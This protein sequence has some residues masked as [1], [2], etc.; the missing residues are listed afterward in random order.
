M[1][2]KSQKGRHPEVSGIQT[3]WEFHE[4]VAFERAKLVSEA[5]E[6]RFGELEKAMHTILAKQDSEGALALITRGALALGSSDIHYDTSEA[7]VFV[8][9]RIDGSLVTIITLS[10]QE[11][12]LIL[13]RIKYKSNLKLNLTDIPQ[14]GK[15][16]ILENDRIDVRVATLPVKYGENVVCRILDST[17]SIPKLEELGLQ[18]TAKRQV[19][20]ALQEK[21]GTILVTWPTG[22]GKTTT[23]Y[24]ILQ[25]LNTPDKKIITL[26][27]PIEYELPWVVQSEVNDKT[28]YTYTTGLRAILRQDP[29]I[30][31]VWEIRDLESAT[32][33][34]QAA[35]TGHLVLST[36]HTKSASET[37]ERL[38]NMGIPSYILS[39]WLDI[40]IA[41]RLVRRLCPYCLESHEATAKEIDIIKWMMKD[42]GIAKAFAERRKWVYK[43]YSSKGCEQC[44]MTGYHGRIGIYE[45]LAL[46]DA[47][48]TLIRDAASP[49]EIM[50]A[51]RSNDLVLMREDGIMKA[52]RGKTSLEE[53]FRVVT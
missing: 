32:I 43:L 18:W 15:Y 50:E 5:E 21:N 13:E 35:M 47:I 33:A 26:E 52:M 51:A 44:G 6:K 24:S 48:R 30:V 31:M 39:S 27:D 3:E 38:M 46:N 45:V 4:V 2:A 40:I 8:R 37:I 53:L 23:L 28:D 10:K 22:S 12:K 20:R 17:A 49:R 42:L 1:A 14:D 41:Q 11:Y 16:R 7:W 19:D 29:D 36:L 9:I 25:S 34:M